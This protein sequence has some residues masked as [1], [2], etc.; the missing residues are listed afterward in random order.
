M[1]HLPLRSLLAAYSTL[2]LLA[3]SSGGF[4]GSATIFHSFWC[5]TNGANPQAPLVLGRDGAFYGTTIGG[6]TNG[7]YGTVFRFSPPNQFESLY[8]FRHDGDGL[9]PTSIVQA[10]DG[11]LYGCMPKSG[12]LAYGALFCMTTGGIFSQLYSFTNGV[13][14]FGPS[15]LISGAD[16]ALYGT[17]ESTVFRATLDGNLT[18]L[19]R[20]LGASGIT[21]GTDETL[22]VVVNTGGAHGKGA[23]YKVS[24]PGE[25]I[26]L[27]SFS[28]GDGSIPNGLTVGNGGSLYGIT[29][30]GGADNYG[31]IFKLDP[32]GTFSILHSFTNGID[33]SMSQTP[34][35]LGFDGDLYGTAGSFFKLAPNGAFTP[36]SAP[37][38][39]AQ[40][41]QGN[42][43][44][45]YGALPWGGFAIPLAA[46]STAAKPEAHSLPDVASAGPEIETLGSIFRLDRTGKFTNL[47]S[48]SGVNDGGAPKALV[49]ASDGDLYGITANGGTTSSIIGAVFK[50]SP[51]G[52]FDVIHSIIEGE[53]GGT[54]TINA[55]ADGQLYG[56]DLAT[57]FYAGSGSVF[58]VTLDG[59]FNSIYAFHRPE[60][61]DLPVAPV[62]QGDDGYLYG[63]TV[64][65]GVSGYGNLF[66]V[67]TNGAFTNLYSFTD[68][69]DGA[70][71]GTALVQGADS[72]LYGTTPLGGAHD[73]GT[74]FKISTNGD[75]TLLYTFTNGLD[76]ANP[77]TSLAL[78]DDG[79][80]YGTTYYGGASNRGTVFRMTPD[81][82]FTTLHVFKGADGASPQGTVVTGPD[83][84][85][86]GVAPIGGAHGFGAI[87]VVNTNGQFATLYSFP[88]GN[89]GAGP[90]AIAVGNDG[91][92]YGTTYSGGAG[93]NGTFFKLI[94]PY[95]PAMTKQPPANI[96]Q[97]SGSVLTLGALA[98]GM[99]P[100]RYQWQCNGTNLSN[101]R[102][103]SG[104]TSNV[105]T[106]NPLT[107]DLGR[108]R[109]LPSRP[110]FGEAAAS[111]Y[112]GA[113]AAARSE[114]APYQF[115]LI[116][117]NHYGATT[118]TPSAVV[119]FSDT[120]PPTVSISVPA[121]NGRTYNNLI[122]G[123]ATDNSRVAAVNYWITN[124]NN[125][126][127]ITASG[128]A[129]LGSSLTNPTWS[130]TG[131]ALPGTNDV[132]VQSV[133][134]SGN[135]SKP[136][137]R[138]FFLAVPSRFSLTH[139]GSG[140]VTGAASVPGGV[141]PTNN[142][143]L[144]I[145]EAYI[146]AANA[147]TNW[148]FVNWTSGDSVLGSNASLRFVMESG[149]A[150]QAHFAT[151]TFA[152]LAGAYNGLFYQSNNVT[153]ATA[154][155]LENLV[156]SKAGVYSARLE[157]DGDSFGVSGQFDPSGHASNN[158][159]RSADAG[160]DLILDMMLNAATKQITGGVSGTN[161]APWTS[162]LLANLSSNT[163]GSGQYT[164]L[165]PP[166]LANSN[167]PPG[168]GFLLLTNHLGSVTI[169]GQL[170]NGAA[171]YK[172]APVDI[173]GRAPL[174]ANA[175]TFGNSLLFGWIN[176]A[177]YPPAA[178]LTWIQSPGTYFYRGGFTNTVTAMGSRWASPP[179]P[180]NS[181]RLNMT[182]SGGGLG[183]NVESVVFFTNGS[184]RYISG[185][186]W[187]KALG[188]QIDR[189]SGWL[190]IS[191]T[192]GQP[193]QGAWLQNAGFGGG[194]FVLGTNFG[195]FTLRKP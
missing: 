82:A 65:G 133:D 59:Q 31:V 122:S 73:D 116:V 148:S 2:T 29:S 40:L 79:N 173:F 62:I 48:F 89:G 150:I 147:A 163:P 83:G 112:Q 118:S 164:L 191:F 86:F 75:F 193:S 185:P 81:G 7:G 9:G 14:G 36:I 136:A 22:Y 37:G 55:G 50:A 132:A 6:G 53:T 129:A 137:P 78:A 155:M 107:S 121:P 168:Y 43:G 130:V 47:F 10:F 93:G 45:F 126:A 113:I 70:E 88:G 114:I 26:L 151:N 178:S 72:F 188:C 67:S 161:E 127:I 175:S 156:L 124:V 110:D 57:K 85:V 54:F 120:N 98:E 84:N 34:L 170:G 21:Q 176:L 61:G 179:E 69:L 158:I 42:D 184:L 94:I 111:P 102:S 186:V 159:K 95:A 141:P 97:A 194:Y 16:G 25:N 71:P 169:T 3:G 30:G 195:A 144:N 49:K 17:T 187:T 90:N 80:F 28:G 140:S 66:K 165:L 104:A 172:T 11:D 108:A 76:G 119:I 145:G 15:T 189:K 51:D 143:L 68:G 154:G 20:I 183:S 142:A 38:Y 99:I 171:L 101:S 64:G 139:T 35:T 12:P 174:C 100:L 8:S 41:T 44:K 177:A 181:Q 39:L 157:L 4:A 52:L 106:I 190:N 123:A 153:V 192:S 33:G 115:R 96:S 180:I 105:L 13:D 87:W 60:E 74:V 56:T 125:G 91:K 146:L 182:F 117:S 109:L 92:L 131:A 149:L 152:K 167:S 24:R 63:S 5:F 77:S 23:V 32:N 27:H 1:K 58:T 19:G 103:I 138:Q 46:R 135:V 160:S 162:D 18:V 134:F 166:N 128:Q